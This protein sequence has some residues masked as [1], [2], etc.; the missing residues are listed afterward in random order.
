MFRLQLGIC[1][2]K[3]NCTMDWSVLVRLPYCGFGTKETFQNFVRQF[4]KTISS[5]YSNP[6]PNLSVF[7]SCEE[8]LNPDMI[9]KSIQT[10]ILKFNMFSNVLERPSSIHTRYIAAQK[11]ITNKCIQYKAKH[12][13]SSFVWVLFISTK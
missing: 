8:S 6:C 12:K 1:R 13:L 4:L 10:D 5:L 11:Y 9:R 7:L 2:E 3:Q